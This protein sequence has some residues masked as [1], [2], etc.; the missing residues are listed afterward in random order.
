MEEVGEHDE[1]RR[2]RDARGEAPSAVALAHVAGGPDGA[3]RARGPAERVFRSPGAG[4]SIGHG[5]GTSSITVVPEPGDEK[6]RARPPTVL[7]RPTT[8]SA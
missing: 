5:F 2:D 8:D 6:I 1:R 3:H 4:G 7:R